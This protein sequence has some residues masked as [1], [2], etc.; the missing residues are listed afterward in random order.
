LRIDRLTE[1][2]RL[3]LIKAFGAD[4]VRFEDR[5]PPDGHL[6]ELDTVTAIVTVTLATVD[7]AAMALA[8][9]LAGG[10]RKTVVRDHLVIET[11]Q[12]RLVRKLEVTSSSREA[13]Q[14]EIVRQLLAELPKA[15]SFPSSPSD[16]ET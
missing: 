11:P 8:L 10:G 16:P 2:D 7:I 9:W 15:P 12:G 3:E 5:R 4:A 1:L 6:G 14:P 13:L